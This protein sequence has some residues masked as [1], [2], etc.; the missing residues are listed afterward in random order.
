M[1]KLPLNYIDHI[2]KEIDFLQRSRSGK[3]EEDFAND[4]MMQRAF[5]RS[6]EIIG[7][8]VKKLDDDLKAKHA[9]VEWRKISGMRDKLIHEYFGIDYTLVWNV[10]T[11][12]IDPLKEQLLQIKQDLK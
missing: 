9:D 10:I 5:A 3:T 12:K 4:E 8:A 11:D 2:L 1:S 6:I 7:E